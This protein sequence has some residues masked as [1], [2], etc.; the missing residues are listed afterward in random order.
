MITIESIR[1]CVE[2]ADS[3][4]QVLARLGG[5]MAAHDSALGIRL[6][7]MGMDAASQKTD[8]DCFRALLNSTAYGGPNAQS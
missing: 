2:V 1:A 7:Q 4:A 8:A 6:L 5:M 3:P